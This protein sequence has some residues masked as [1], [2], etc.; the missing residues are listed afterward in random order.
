MIRD[1]IEAVKIFGV[2]VEVALVLFAGGVVCYVS[3]LIYEVIFV[4]DPVFVVAAMPDFSSGL[5]ACCEGVSALEV[6]DAF[7]C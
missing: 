1:G 7:G 2:D 5:L 6:L 4:S 3:R